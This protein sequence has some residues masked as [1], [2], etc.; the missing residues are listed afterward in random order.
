MFLLR[1]LLLDD[2]NGNCFCRPTHNQETPTR[3]TGLLSF[4]LGWR[5]RNKVK[6]LHFACFKCWYFIFLSFSLQWN[7]GDWNIVA[8]YTPKQSSINHKTVQKAIFFVIQFQESVFSFLFLTICALSRLR[9]VKFYG[10]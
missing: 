3:K 4:G 5:D 8:R 2:Y 9:K 1:Q 6:H 10:P 7:N